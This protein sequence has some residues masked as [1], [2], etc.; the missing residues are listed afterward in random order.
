MKRCL[1]AS[2][3]GLCL[4]LTPTWA[5][6]KS[7]HAM[8]GLASH[9]HETG[10]LTASGER[11]SVHALTAAHRTLPFGTRVVVRRGGRSVAVRITDRGPFVRGR[12]IDLS[13]AAFRA[14]APLS[15][16]VVRVRL[17]VAERK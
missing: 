9:Y 11:Y 4:A 16:G 15:A 12:V 14:I 13:P 17:S 2:A 10:N 8:N 7:R 3:L 1:R 6:A 5:F